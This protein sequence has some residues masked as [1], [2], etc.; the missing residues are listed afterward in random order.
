MKILGPIDI[1]IVRARDKKICAAL[2]L[3]N[4]YME[5]YVHPKDFQCFEVKIRGI[6]YSI[7]SI[8]SNITGERSPEN[9]IIWHG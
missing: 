7:K 5:D 9:R 3:G 8:R 4:H 1:A 2:Q 6:L